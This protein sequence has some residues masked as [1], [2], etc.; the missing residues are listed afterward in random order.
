MKSECGR[1]FLGT[2]DRRF[3]GGGSVKFTA[4]GK[5]MVTITVTKYPSLG[6][7]ATVFTL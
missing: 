4:S 6:G 3:P 2:K 5:C 7:T 1:C